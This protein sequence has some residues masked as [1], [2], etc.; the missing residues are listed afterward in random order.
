MRPLRLSRLIYNV[1]KM[2]PSEGDTDRGTPG[3]GQTT[4]KDERSQANVLGLTLV[5]GLVIVGSVVVVAFGA[6]AISDSQETLSIQRAEK[7]MTQFDSRAALVALGTTD[8]QRI[9]FGAGTAS[10]FNLNKNSGFMRV[11]RENLNNGNTTRLVQE[12]L[13]AIVYEIDRQ[14]LAYQ[15]GGVWR[16]SGNNSVMVSPPEFHFRNG[17]L[18]LPIIKVDGER[19]LGSSVAVSHNKTTRT[20]P[21]STV[22]SRDNP[23]TNHKVVVTVK[24]DYYK[25]WGEY[26]ETRTDGEV[27]FDHDKNIA[28]LTLVSPIGKQKVTAAVASLSTSG[29]FSVSG[30][31][32][33]PCGAAGP[34][35]S[36]PY[37]DSYNSSGTSNEYCAQ[38]TDDNGN[39]TYGGDIDISG[40]SGASDING[41]LKSGGSVEV[42]AGGGQPA[43]AGDIY[44]TDSCAVPT[45]PPSDCD[46]QTGGDAIQLNDGAL[47]PSRPIN[48][49]INSTADEIQS[50]ND[51]SGAEIAG[52]RLD[53][54]ASGP[55]DTVTL[56]EGI[57]YL[58]KI[59]LSG[60]DKLKVDTSSGDVTIAVRENINIDGDQIRVFGD[61]VTR[62]YVAGESTGPSGNHLQITGTGEIAVDNDDAPELRVYGKD[63]FTVSISHG[64]FTG[65][66]YAPPGQSGTGSLHIDHGALFGGAIIAD[67][68]IGTHG[69]VHYD[70]ALRNQQIVSRSAKIVKVTYLHISVNRITVSGG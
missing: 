3:S 53:F 52:N 33:N 64:K 6:S 8:I 37:A 43:V 11:S 59:D 19:S 38:S 23:L 29:S 36:R 34:P 9:D 2:V 16:A 24:S 45:G 28:N 20:Y 51:N 70:E 63:D 68:T 31:S 65:A 55:S 15:G 12:D 39:I 26:F 4:G 58:D 62:I 42:S 66:I 25:A 50:S 21:L 49:F 47:Q 61:N 7:A 44:Y 14:S 46:A 69:S 41:S 17:T 1:Y 22:A 56:T 32:G 60:G 10:E 18:T 40:G 35:G 54:G 5:F 30:A 27:D 57:Y 48:A 13:G 67:T